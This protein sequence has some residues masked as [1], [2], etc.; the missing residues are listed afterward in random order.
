MKPFYCATLFIFFFG[1]LAGQSFE[2]GPYTNKTISLPLIADFNGDD[3]IDVL[4]VSRFFSPTGTLKLHINN[5]E[6]DSI[7]FDTKD[8]GFSVKGN[9]GFG[10]FDN[11]GDMDLVVIES[12]N[13]TIQILFNNGDGTFETSSIDSEVAY[14]FET[15]DLDGDGDIDI[16]SLNGD[17]ESAYLLLND[18]N[19]GFTTSDLLSDVEDLQTFK[20][21]DLDGDNDVDIIVGFDDFFD[22]K[23]IVLDNQGDATFVEKNIIE[24]GVGSLENLQIIDINRDGLMDVIYSSDKSSILYGL[25]NNGEESYTL[26]NLAQG[27]GSLRSFSVA[28]YNSDGIMDIMLGC[29]SADNTYHQGLSSASLEYD[30]EVIT[31][32]QPMFYIVNGDFDSDSDLDVVLSNGDFWWVIN[33]LEQG[34]VNVEELNEDLYQVFPNPFKDNISLSG[35][36]SDKRLL[37]SDMLGQTVFEASKSALSYNLED[38]STGCYFLSIIESSTGKVEQTTK[39]VKID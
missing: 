15:S 26:T 6:P 34:T 28:D 35:L 16:V 29:N 10:D 27:E 4:G 14:R 13:D 39:I 11:D 3:R 21:E 32:I 8:L 20:L 25:L 24:N 36:E 37:I 22:S 33:E 12:E 5:S 19:G 38:L 9:P 2:R 31:G 17:I 18:G 7:L 30:S 23:I 1:S